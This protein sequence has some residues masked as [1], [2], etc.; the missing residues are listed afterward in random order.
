MTTTTFTNG[1]FI[2][3]PNGADTLDRLKKTVD[4]YK[5]EFKKTH[6]AVDAARIEMATRGAC[7][8]VVPLSADQATFLGRI[9]LGLDIAGTI[10]PAMMPTRIEAKHFTKSSRVRNL[11]HGGMLGLVSGRLMDSSR[12][13]KR[14]RTYHAMSVIRRA[15]NQAGCAHV[16]WSIPEFQ[17]RFNMNVQ[18]FKFGPTPFTS[19]TMEDTIVQF[20]LLNT[21][22]N[23]DRF[24]EECTAFA[25]D[26]THSRTVASTRHVMSNQW[27]TLFICGFSKLCS[28]RIRMAQVSNV[29]IPKID[30]CVNIVN[31]FRLMAENIGWILS[32]PLMQC[33]TNMGRLADSFVERLGYMAQEGVEHSA[34]ILGHYFPEMMT[35]E[36]HIHVNPAGDVYRTPQ[37]QIADDDALFG[38]LK[39]TYQ[40]LMPAALPARGCQSSKSSDSDSEYD[41]YDDYDGNDGN[42]Y[43]SDSSD[44]DYDYRMG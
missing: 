24:L 32:D 20:N 18:L 12:T 21:K 31:V 15:N 26:P 19:L 30:R 16:K 1:R 38:P 27:I 4:D 13:K 39:A 2:I 25:N 8:L 14:L 36:L 5:E 6:M 40:A 17:R 23:R 29:S 10:A 22:E 42:D 43:G 35:P 11:V 44:S 9:A 33:I 28:F 7:K 41:D 37:M 34:Y 3:T